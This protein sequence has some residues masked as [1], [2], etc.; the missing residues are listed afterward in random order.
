MVNNTVVLTSG[1]Q[2]QDSSQK[3]SGL[4]M[5]VFSGDLDKILAA[6]IIAN[7]AAAMDIPVS[8]FFTFWGL[9][10]LRRDG[11]VELKSPKTFMEKMFGWMMPKGPNKLTLS[12]MNMGGLGTVLMKK[13]M[14][15]KNVYDLPKL[16]KSAQEQGVRLI[17]CTMSMDVMGIKKEELIE[18]I[19]FG[20]VGTFIDS[21]DKG[22][23]S[24]FV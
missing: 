5:V 11:P 9:N 23:I 4:T 19:S 18:G 22:N 16:I 14:A 24:L 2:V 21:A 20:G 6:F 17:A 3:A 8:L 13:E 15:K 1:A 7:G 10:V 12:R